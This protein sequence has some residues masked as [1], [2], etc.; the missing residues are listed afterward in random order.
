MLSAYLLERVAGMRGAFMQHGYVS[1]YSMLR[2]FCIIYFQFP[3][4]VF[5][6]QDLPY[7]ITTGRNFCTDYM[8]E[9]LSIFARNL[10][11]PKIHFDAWNFQRSF[12]V[13]VILKL[14]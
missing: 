1:Y 14:K 3:D 10:E 9:N 13:G 4:E 7:F 8:L 12:N 11:L 6:S 5:K 2:N